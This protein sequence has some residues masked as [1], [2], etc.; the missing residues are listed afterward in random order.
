MT[1]LS[2]CSFCGLQAAVTEFILFNHVDNTANVEGSSSLLHLQTL[3][4]VKEVATQPTKEEEDECDRIDPE[5]IK[6]K[7]NQPEWDD[8]R[9][10]LQSIT[11]SIFTDWGHRDLKR[12]LSLNVFQLR[13]KYVEQIIKETLERRWDQISTEN[14]SEFYSE[15]RSFFVTFIVALML[16]PQIDERFHSVTLFECESEESWA[17]SFTLLLRRCS[18]LHSSRWVQRRINVE[19]FPFKRYE[20]R[21]SSKTCGEE[22]RFENMTFKRSKSVLEEE[23]SNSLPSSTDGN[24]FF[25]FRWVHAPRTAASNK[26]WTGSPNTPPKDSGVTAVETPIEFEP[27]WIWGIRSL[28]RFWIDTLYSIVWSKNAAMAG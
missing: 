1:L 2:K 4:A 26:V 15:S 28:R 20:S 21:W 6:E 3:N 22:E 27:I 16:L 12:S 14:P 18:N 7:R 13:E 17:H 19:Y 23:S 10:R 9:F 8:N 24:V 11:I 25:S 5:W